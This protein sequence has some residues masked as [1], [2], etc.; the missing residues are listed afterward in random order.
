MCFGFWILLPGTKWSSSGTTVSPQSH[1][2]L[3]IVPGHL[4]ECSIPSVLS[5]V[6]PALWC[7]CLKLS[8]GC[9]CLC[10]KPW[11][12]AELSAR[13][14]VLSW[15]QGLGARPM[16]RS[17]RVHRGLLR[18]P[19][20]CLG[21]GLLTE[22]E[23]EL[24]QG[25]GTCSVSAPALADTRTPPCFPGWFQNSAGSWAIGSLIPVRAARGTVA[26]HLLSWTQAKAQAASWHL[27]YCPPFQC[28]FHRNTEHTWSLECW[29]STPK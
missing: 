9:G 29:I 7:W 28:Q 12:D 15:Q 4:F 13:G 6:S 1:P 16:V 14:R 22:E 25:E 11:A 20:A 5:S 27:V 24:E 18:S 21:L 3:Q 10:R 17:W 23:S 2:S 19:R 26:V 8:S